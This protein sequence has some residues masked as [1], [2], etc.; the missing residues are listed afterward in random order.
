VG[1]NAL[2]AYEKE[3]ENAKKGLPSSERVFEKVTL[4]AGV[5]MW[6]APQTLLTLWATRVEHPQ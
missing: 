5:R 2:S 4:N 6:G 3:A 1:C